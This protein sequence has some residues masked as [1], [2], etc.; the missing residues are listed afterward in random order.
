MTQALLLIFLIWAV[1]LVPLGVRRRQEH[2]RRTVD[3]FE[4]AMDVLAGDNDHATEWK[5]QPVAGRVSALQHRRLQLFSAALRSTGVA[6]LVAVIFGGWLWVLFAV[7]VG[8]TAAYA[9][10][11][12]QAKRQRDYADM[13]VRELQTYRGQVRPTGRARSKTPESR[14]VRL[15]S[16]RAQ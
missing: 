8:L 15:R 9:G 10:V 13:V 6:G 3:G 5:Q 11:L 16:Y 1:L 2:P 14:S 4:R 7:A 12:R